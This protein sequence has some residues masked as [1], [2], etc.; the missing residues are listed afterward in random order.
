[1]LEQW[2]LKWEVLQLFEVLSSPLLGYIM[3]VIDYGVEC[4]FSKTL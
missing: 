1:M 3:Q 4:Y 2:I